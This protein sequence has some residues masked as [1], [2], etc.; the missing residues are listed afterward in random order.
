VPLVVLRLAANLATAFCGQ[1]Q[2][3]AWMALTEQILICMLAIP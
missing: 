1:T 3:I 2:R